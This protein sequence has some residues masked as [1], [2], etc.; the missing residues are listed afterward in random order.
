[1]HCT[2]RLDCVYAWACESLQGPSQLPATPTPAS[3]SAAIAAYEKERKRRAVAKEARRKRREA[4]RK[5]QEALAPKPG[6]AS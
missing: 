2:A 6:R 1:M 4:R 3:S 5:L